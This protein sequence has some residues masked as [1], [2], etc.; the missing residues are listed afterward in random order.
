MATIELN[1][2]GGIVSIFDGSAWQ[3]EPFT[4]SDELHLIA[5]KFGLRLNFDRLL[6]YDNNSYGV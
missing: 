5:H 2:S 3:R 4:N 6:C 1:D